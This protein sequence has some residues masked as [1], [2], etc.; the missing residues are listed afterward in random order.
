ML[1]AYGNPLKINEALTELGGVPAV[2]KGGDASKEFE[3]NS[4]GKIHLR[5]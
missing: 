4:E 5:R 1:T 2:E 3:E